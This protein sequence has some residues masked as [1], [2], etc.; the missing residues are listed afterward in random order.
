METNDR[1]RPFLLSLEARPA[2]KAG[3]SISALYDENW[4]KMR[5]GRACRTVFA[6][7]ALNET[8]QHRYTV[9]LFEDD[10]GAPHAFCNCLSRVPC[11]HIYACLDELL[12]ERQP[13][14]GGPK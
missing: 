1:K 2:A 3:E 12:T 14:F 6:Y 7:V 5:S 11:K 8:K 9:E 13:N 10:S 4:S